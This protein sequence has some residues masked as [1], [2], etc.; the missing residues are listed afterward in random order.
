MS[1]C[2]LSKYT[3]CDYSLL[4]TDAEM[5][6]R[7]VINTI[8]NYD[9]NNPLRLYKPCNLIKYSEYNFGLS[10]ENNFITRFNCK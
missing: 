10:F 1:D 3:D 9:F 4:I 8:I 2:R 6:N 5:K 7:K